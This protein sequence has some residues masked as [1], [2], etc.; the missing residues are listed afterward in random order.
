MIAIFVD[1]VDTTEKDKNCLK[2]IWNECSCLKTV[3]F[4]EQD[5]F[6]FDT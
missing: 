3:V 5:M 6:I 4:Y 2:N 1:Q